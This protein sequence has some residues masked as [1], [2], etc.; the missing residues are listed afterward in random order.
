M[1]LDHIHLVAI[2]H[3][4]VNR[5]MVANPYLVLNPSLITVFRGK[6]QVILN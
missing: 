4:V 6:L 2:L 5:H 1:S 3:M